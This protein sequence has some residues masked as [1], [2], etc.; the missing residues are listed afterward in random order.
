M[1]FRLLW[2]TDLCT[3]FPG[4]VNAVVVSGV[5]WSRETVVWSEIYKISS[6][7]IG[8]RKS[9]AA[10]D[11][12]KGNK[13]LSSVAKPLDVQTKRGKV[14]LFYSFYHIFWGECVYLG[15]C[16]IYNAVVIVFLAWRSFSTK[17][18]ILWYDPG[19]QRDLG[20]N[21]LVISWICK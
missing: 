13:R 11:L 5:I 15:F 20:S 8:K 4:K 2:T 1:F 12:N 17:P 18:E 21:S 14:G 3:D 19:L 9:M 6:R 7:F 16:S 10:P